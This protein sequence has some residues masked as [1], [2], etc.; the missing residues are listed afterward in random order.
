MKKHIILLVIPL[1]ILIFYVCHKGADVVEGN[2][3]PHE[4][5][6]RSTLCPKETIGKSSEIRYLLTRE[7][8]MK[9]AMG[10]LYIQKDPYESEIFKKDI[11]SLQSDFKC[12]KKTKDVTGVLIQRS[13]Y[14]KKDFGNQRGTDLK[15]WDHLNEKCRKDCYN[16]PDCSYVHR[17]VQD[18]NRD[19]FK[20]TCDIYNTTKKLGIKKTD[21]KKTD[22]QIC[23]YKR[24]YPHGRLCGKKCFMNDRAFDNSNGGKHARQLLHI[25]DKVTY[26]DCWDTCHKMGNRNNGYH[27]KYKRWHGGMTRRRGDEMNYF[28]CVAFSHDGGG[29]V[30]GGRGYD[31]PFKRPAGESKGTCI[32]SKY[33]RWR[34]PARGSSTTSSDLWTWPISVDKGVTSKE[35]GTLL[36]MRECD[37]GKANKKLV[38][39]N[40][41]LYYKV[42]R[43]NCAVKSLPV[44]DSKTCSKEKLGWEP[45]VIDDKQHDGTHCP[46]FPKGDDTIA[47]Q[48]RTIKLAQKYCDT[49]GNDCAGI[50][51]YVRFKKP[52]ICFRKKMDNKAQSKPKFSGDCYI[53]MESKEDI[54]SRESKEVKKFRS[55]KTCYKKV[56]GSGNRKYAKY[57]GD[58]DTTN[59]GKTCQDWDSQYPHKHRAGGHYTDAATKRGID[60]DMGKRTDDEG[61][62]MCANP[63]KSPKP[64]CYT[65]NPKKRWDWCSSLTS[66]KTEGGYK[67]QHWHLHS[68][69]KHSQ[70]DPDYKRS[71]FSHNYCRDTDGSGKPW[72]YTTDQKKRW[73]YCDIKKC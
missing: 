36:V 68:P 73:E 27:G 33:G 45:V 8:N 51:A 46:Y 62:A 4:Q 31:I 48:N 13:T 69:H 11:R 60:A 59:T 26:N 44:C 35:S 47:K 32:V 49:L 18:V 2:V 12:G 56:S 25:G 38:K 30:S 28:A 17:K 65:T 53:K 21:H 67:C 7:E 29:K 43:H 70:W 55:T 3:I 5:P 39:V 52:Q 64:W 61:I 9:G 50:T 20:L 58:V 57:T 37:I 66:T 34:P 19:N 6:H 54:K 40:P 23:E 71:G 15:K 14:T 42:N 10:G 22:E 24:N 72:C 63:D 1:I 16:N 41:T